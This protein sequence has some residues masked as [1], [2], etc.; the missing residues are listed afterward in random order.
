MNKHLKYNLIND[1]YYV[2]EL[3]KNIYKID[4]FIDIK[5]I[6]IKGGT[7]DPDLDFIIDLRNS[8]I[9]ITKRT[10]KQIKL[11]F[12]I[13]RTL[14]NPSRTKKIALITQTPKQVVW[15]TLFKYYE[16]ENIICEIF[17]SLKAAL[18]WI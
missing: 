2:Y 17:S 5:C 16:E 13:L 15:A 10:H 14:T 12:K 11:Y 18:K 8:E 9:I 1:K 7:L 3:N 4:E 6:D